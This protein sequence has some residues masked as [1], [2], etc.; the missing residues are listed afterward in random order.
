MRRRGPDRLA[1][2]C[3][4]S[5]WFIDVVDRGLSPFLLN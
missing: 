2:G 5:D 4:E 1:S 3:G